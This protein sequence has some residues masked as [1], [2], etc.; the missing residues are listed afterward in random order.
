MENI[1]EF[2]KPIEFKEFMSMVANGYVTNQNVT[3]V[4]IVFLFITNFE[5]VD[6]WTIGFTSMLR[7]L[8]DKYLTNNSKETIQNVVKHDEDGMPIF[9][10]TIGQGIPNGVN[11]LIY[12]II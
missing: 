7:H 8:C 3:R 12:T 4:E 1:G 5:I 6:L 11:T 10:T 2:S 9:Y